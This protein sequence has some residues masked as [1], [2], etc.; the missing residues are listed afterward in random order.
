MQ[1]VPNPPKR[2][3]T[4]L[5]GTSTLHPDRNQGPRL[6]KVVTSKD[7]TIKFAL[8][9]GKLLVQIGDYPCPVDAISTHALL[10]LLYINRDAIILEA[11]EARL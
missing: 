10:N 6:A 1:G 8:D 5:K 4:P 9:G 7:N 11:R 3:G 2:E